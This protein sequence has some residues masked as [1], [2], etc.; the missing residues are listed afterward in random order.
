MAQTFCTSTDGGR[1]DGKGIKRAAADLYIIVSHPFH[2]R[3]KFWRIKKQVI[4]LLPTKISINDMKVSVKPTLISC[5]IDGKIC[6]AVAGCESTQPC[7]LCGDKPSEM[8][9]ER[10]IKQKTVN[11]NLLS[12]GLST[13]HT[14]IRFFECV[15]HLSYRLEIKSWQAR[16]A[17][18]KNNVAG[19]KKKTKFK[20]EL[21][22]LVD[23]P[24]QQTGNTNVGDTALKHLTSTYKKP[25]NYILEST[26]GTQ[27]PSIYSKLTCSSQNKYRKI[28]NE[29]RELLEIRTPAPIDQDAIL[30][31]SSDTEESE[32]D[33]EESDL[34]SE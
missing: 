2:R 22:L 3:A 28:S 26:H 24:K 13:L 1:T 21:G 25:E 16:G 20:S 5:M 9:D 27:C 31:E 34:G 14:W 19:K 12:L 11:R 23:M 6:N 7:Y 33:L 17:K 32:S 4:S 30:L 18:N 8:N 15:L 29:V 10:I